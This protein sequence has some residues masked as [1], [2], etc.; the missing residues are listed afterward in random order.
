MSKAGWPANVK[1]SIEKLCIDLSAAL[2]VIVIDLD[3]LVNHEED[4]AGKNPAI[5]FE[6]L[7]LDT[8]PVDPLYKLSFSVGGKTTDDPGGYKLLE[9]QG[10]LATLFE[11]RR[12]LQFY[13]FTGAEG[14]PI[15][16]VGLGTVAEFSTFGQQASDRSGVRM[17]TVTISLQRIPVERAAP[18]VEG[19]YGAIIAEAIGS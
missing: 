10:A 11:S 19:F 13:D 4:L 18:P 7:R 5:L 8:T 12:W 6:I 16:L 1:S 14:D 17:A 2:N 9:I 3:D 15:G